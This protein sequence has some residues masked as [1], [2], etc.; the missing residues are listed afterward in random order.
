[1]LKGRD[2]VRA[3]R[4]PQT[5]GTRLDL[6]QERRAPPGV[7]PAR[8]DHSSSRDTRRLWFC[9]A[10]VPGEYH[11][12]E[13]AFTIMALAAKETNRA[14]FD[15]LA[16]AGEAREAVGP[17]VSLYQVA[18]AFTRID[19]ETLDEF[20]G[21]WAGWLADGSEGLLHRPTTL[22]EQCAD[23]SWRRG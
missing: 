23:G 10:Q 22:P 13:T 12:F 1:M 7:F 5:P 3:R 2:K 15:L 6:H 4:Q 17:G 11:G 16:D 14:P 8:D 18:W 9:D 20:I 21:R 19:G